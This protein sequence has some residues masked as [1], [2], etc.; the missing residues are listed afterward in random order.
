MNEGS[1]SGRRTLLRALLA[2]QSGSVGA[3]YGYAAYIWA[4]QGRWPSHNDPDPSQ[5]CPPCDIA[6][7]L[8]LL[9][10]LLSPVA[11]LLVLYKLPRRQALYQ[12]SLIVIAWLV[13]FSI[14]RWGPGGVTGWFVE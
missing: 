13:W 7:S 3:L 4:H 10:A 12:L 5:F 14:L 11:A 6:I 9:L 2:L 1:R 8:A